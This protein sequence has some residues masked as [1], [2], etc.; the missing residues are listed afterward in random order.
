MATEPNERL[1]VLVV[2][3]HPLV[4]RE[5]RA[6]LEREPEVEVVGEAA[7]VGRALEHARELRAHTLVMQRI[8]GLDVDAARSARATGVGVVVLP[9]AVDPGAAAHAL[10]IV[11][12]GRSEAGLT[13]REMEV[14]DELAQGKGNK[15]IAWALALGQETVKTHVKHIL[16]KLGVQSRTEAAVRA[17]TLGLVRHVEVGRTGSG[18]PGG[19]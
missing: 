11:G 12:A 17:V 1:R 19:P 4:R 2:D 10:R 13:E 15:E 8:D 18:P 3:G 7:R 16:R 9:A 14:L 6:L 5:L